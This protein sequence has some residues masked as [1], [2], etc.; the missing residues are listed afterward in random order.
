MLNNQ[1]Q[2]RIG[3]EIAQKIR[4]TAALLNYHPN[5]IARSLKTR[6][7]YTI[8]LV[9]ADISNP[10]SSGLARIIEDEA[11]QQGYTV[12]F[13]SSDESE[14]K[15]EKL[16]GT[17]LNRQVDGLIIAPPA[18]AESQIEQLQKQDIP[19]VLI[20]RYFPNLE[21]N[22]VILDNYVATFDAVKHLQTSGFRNIG[23]LNYQS[24]LLHLRERKRGYLDAIGK[25]GDQNTASL[26]EIPINNDPVEIERAVTELLQDSQPVDALIFAA[27]RLAVSALRYLVTLPLKIP[28]NLGLVGFDETESFDFFYSPLTYIRQPM[29]EM[30][31]AALRILVDNIRGKSAPETIILKPELIVRGSSVR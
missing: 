4:E 22:S 25:P 17:L 24:P 10:F 6:K 1:K 30:G 16:L 18:G 7:T 5:Q 13:G 3:R 15:S 31:R 19:F 2:G 9:V 21:T 8:G 23:L 14:A 27:N 29:R 28:D 12:I 26:K 20:D 11:D